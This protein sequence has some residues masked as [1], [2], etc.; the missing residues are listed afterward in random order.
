M[1]SEY[2][3]RCRELADFKPSEGYSPTIHTS[4]GYIKLLNYAEQLEDAARK[5]NG[6]IEQVERVI[7]DNVEKLEAGY[8]PDELFDGYGVL[9]NIES[10]NKDL[11]T[12]DQ[13]SDVLDSA[14]RLIKQRIKDDV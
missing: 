3:K 6:I 12:S 1:R 10:K 5:Y 13:I 14:V 11:I 9:H 7:K 4:P 2:L 8:I